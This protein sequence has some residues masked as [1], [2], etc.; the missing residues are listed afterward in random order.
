MN[1]NDWRLTNQMNYLF[2]KKLIKG[3]FKPY[4]EGWEHELCEFCAE[5][6]D[7]TTD[8]VYSTEDRYHWICKECYNDFKDMFEWEMSNHSL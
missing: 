2:R 6:I 3:A 7:N 4:R 8:E 1:N 5:R